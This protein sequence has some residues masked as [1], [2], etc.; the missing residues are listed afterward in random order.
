VLRDAVT[1]AGGD[2]NQLRDDLERQR[3]A[4]D[5]RLDTNAR[6]AATLGL[7][8]T[9]AYLVGPLIVTGAMDADGFAR[10]FDQ[11]RSAQQQRPPPL[12]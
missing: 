10:I 3:V 11:A 6:A 1:A 4:I 9:P 5:A 8:G 2:W 12:P 7:Q